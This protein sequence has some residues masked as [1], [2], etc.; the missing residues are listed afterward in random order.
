MKS[1][2]YIKTR[3][4]DIDVTPVSQEPQV[5]QIHKARQQILL[6][7]YNN[8]NLQPEHVINLKLNT[9]KEELS[10]FP[11]DQYNHNKKMIEVQIE[12]IEN[13]LD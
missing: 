12:E 10:L 2:L 13:I 5:L 3:F 11:K 9:L 7:L 4:N 8:G 6:W 1:K